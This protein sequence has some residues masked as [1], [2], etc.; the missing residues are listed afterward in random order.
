MPP[1]ACLAAD[2][3]L[4]QPGE[5]V[6]FT[7]CSDFA[8]QTMIYFPHEQDL[9][10]QTTGYVFDSDRRFKYVFNSKGAFAA[11]LQAIGA[12]GTPIREHTVTVVV[13]D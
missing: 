4:I 11:V 5:T 9:A 8:I 12:S 6:T 10:D 1:T 13:R 3:T 7:D 2:R